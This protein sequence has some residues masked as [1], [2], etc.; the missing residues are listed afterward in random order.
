MVKW[1]IGYYGDPFKI[2]QGVT[3]GDP[4]LPKIFNAVVEAVIRRG[5]GGRG[6]GKI[7]PHSGADGIFLYVGD[8]ILVLKRMEWLHW[9]FGIV[10]ILMIK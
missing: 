10:G 1:E 5:G 8:G 9:E 2:Y 6:S 4:I 7:R 3:Q